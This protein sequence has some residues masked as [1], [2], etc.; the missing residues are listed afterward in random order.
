MHRQAHDAQR[1]AVKRWLRAPKDASGGSLGSLYVNDRSGEITHTVMSGGAYRIGDAHLSRFVEVLAEDVR[2][3]ITIPSLSAIHTPVFPM[4]Y[5]LDAKLP[6]SELS[7]D[8]IDTIVRVLDAQ[9]CRFY[10]TRPQPFVAVVCTKSKGADPLPVDGTRWRRVTEGAPATG[11][12]LCLPE[13]R[14]HLET[15]RCTT[16]RRRDGPG[17]YDV[18]KHSVGSV[19]EEGVK[20][21][22][23]CLPAADETVVLSQ[24]DWD[25]FSIPLSAVD[26]SG[27]YVV[28]EDGAYYEP[29]RDARPD[30]SVPGAVAASVLARAQ[31][32]IFSDDTIRL[33][34]GTR[35][36]P[37]DGLW[38][39]GVHVHFKDLLVD[40]HRATFIR[41]Y[42]VQGLQGNHDWMEMMGVAAPDWQD[43]LDVNVYND[44][45]RGG[46]L[47]LV[48]APKMVPC[49]VRHS[50]E[51]KKLWRRSESEACICFAHDGRILDDN[52]Y[53]VTSVHEAGKRSALKLA[54]LEANF[55]MRRCGPR[56][57]ARRPQCS[58]TALSS[59]KGA[60]AGHD[61]RRRRRKR[62]RKRRK[63]RAR[64]KRRVR[65]EDEKLSGSGFEE[66]AI[67]PQLSE[68]LRAEVN[69]H[70]EDQD[71]HGVYKDV[72]VRLV[73]NA[74]RTVFCVNLYGNG[75]RYCMNKGGEHM[76]SRAWMRVTS[77]GA[78]H[79]TSR[80]KCHCKKERVGLY[81]M[82]CKKFASTKSLTV[83]RALTTA[84]HELFPAAS[85]SAAG[86][87]SSSRTAA[88]TPTVPMFADT[89]LV[90][91][92]LNVFDPSS[93]GS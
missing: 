24:A 58:P 60:R 40:I 49:P 84:L 38:K 28:T 26:A 7:E 51:E 17:T 80:M 62:R 18:L 8:A 9:T 45:R 16:W 59:S 43:I 13:L 44:S 71:F 27:S 88:A 19:H 70:T 46:G 79:M 47:R 11:R 36:Q 2:N 57:V 89:P 83:E 34:D 30:L 74:A 92:T 20:E 56:C 10:P 3:G 42:C 55:A 85:Q 12:E 65:T 91:D 67:T 53:T 5:D 90:L 73:V 6:V 14:A 82:P 48:H 75:A 63:R 81:Q 32:Q 78:W 33:S 37:A 77:S 64:R 93:T 23:R 25:A 15:V 86:P 87:A 50:V 41:A 72:S 68:M 69:R 1:S 52:V 35:L 76:S 39:H 66:V 4:F 31:T 61:R 22:L 29:L 21:L 54:Q